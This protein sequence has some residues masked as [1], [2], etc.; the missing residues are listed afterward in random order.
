VNLVSFSGDK[1]LGGQQAGIL[2]GDADLVARTRKNPL[3]R[4]LR[5]D[6]SVIKGLTRTLN[7]LI[8]AKYDEI[9]A[10]RM[11]RMSAD[12]IRTRAE[13]LRERI[14]S[15]EIIAG[16]SVAGGGSTPDQTLP[17]WL[18]AISGDVVQIEKK[19]RAKNIIARIENN[20]VVLDLRTVFPEEEPL[21]VALLST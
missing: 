4:A 15:L 18:L 3:F 16:E 17:T 9:P 1:L 21:I 20:K 11:L 2:T 10:L 5:V 14:P 8:F 13:K 12:E 7:D 19:L 6:K